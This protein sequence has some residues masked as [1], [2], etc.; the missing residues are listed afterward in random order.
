M[1]YNKF[2]A[3]G[4]SYSQIYRS[5]TNKFIGGVCGGLGEYFNIDPSII[6]LVFV[7]LT[8]FG[9]SGIIIYLVLWIII[10]SKSQKGSQDFKERIHEVAQ[11]IKN[12]VKNHR[13]HEPHN[14]HFIA[15]AAILI[16]ILFLLDN[17]GF[18]TY[19]SFGRLWPL[20]LILLGIS[21]ILRK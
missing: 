5:E 19:F 10:P 12:S 4:K 14:R 1:R 20:L 11:D 8:V 13:I 16:G 21:I 2:M 9:G 18:N 3:E 6:R 7:L 15:Y 17:F